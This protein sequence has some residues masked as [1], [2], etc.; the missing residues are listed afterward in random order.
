MPYATELD[1]DIKWGAEAVT[2]VAADAR[3]GY[4]SHERIVAALDSATARMNG[5][6]AKRYSLPIDAAPDGA[7]LLRN[8]ACDLAMGELANTPGARNDIIKEAVVAALKFL[9]D[10]AMG[11]ADIPQNPAPGAPGAAVSPNEAI[12]VA[13]DREFSRN[14]LRAL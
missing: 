6:F 9:N 5:V 8:L 12:V 14:R 13:N 3:T 11:R 4:R 2:L 10:V 7:I 1:L